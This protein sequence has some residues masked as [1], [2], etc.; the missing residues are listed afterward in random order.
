ML[1][2]LFENLH[3]ASIMCKARSH[4]DDWY[5]YRPQRSWGKVIFSEACVKNSVHRKGGGVRGRK[6][7]CGGGGMCGRGRS[8]GVCMVGGVRGGGC[9][10][11]G[12]GVRGIRSM[13][14]LYASYWNAFLFSLFWYRQMLTSKI[15]IVYTQRRYSHSND[16]FKTQNYSQS[17]HLSYSLKWVDCGSMGLFTHNVKRSKV[18]PTKTVTFTVRNFLLPPTNEVARR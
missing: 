11:Q 4:C 3:K 13:S 14:G 6:G 18:P 1:N 17:H 9:A 2:N 7:M 8:W 12:R 5:N 16:I 15:G 10:W